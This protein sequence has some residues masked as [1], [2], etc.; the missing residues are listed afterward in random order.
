MEKG[1]TGPPGPAGAA[2]ERAD[3]AWTAGLFA[4]GLLLR[5][6]H[7]VTVRS[8]PF[9]EHLMLDAAMYDAW[10]RRIAAGALLGEGPFFQ[11]PLYAYFLGALYALAGHDHVTVVLVQSLL[12]SLVAPLIYLA[13][14]PWLSRAAAAA[15]GAI[16]ALYL[17]SIYYGGLILKTWMTV[18]LVALLLLLLSRVLRDEERPTG[19]LVV[20]LVLGLACLTRGNLVLLVPL[21]ALWLLARR[22]R[23]AA[24]AAALLVAGAALAIA[25]ATLHNRLAGGEWIPTT[26]NAGQNFYIGNNALNRSGE[27]AALPF[28]DPNPKHE[29]RDFAA[30]AR[31]RSGRD[32]GYAEA[33]RFWFGEALDWIGENPRAWLALLGRKLGAYWGAYEI[34]DNLDYY[35]YR[36]SAPVLR[37]PVPGFGLVAPLAVLGAVLAWRRPGWPRLLVLLVAVYSLSVVFFFVFSR[38]RMAAMPALFALAGFGLV[39]LWR[40]TGQALRRDGPM[41]LLR[42]AA[43]L[44]LFLALINLPLRAQQGSLT[45]RIAESAGIPVRVEHS[46]TALFNLGLSHA[47]RALEEEE[48]GESLLL[49]ER[50]LRQAVRL[51][52]RFA[53]VHVE[54]GKVLARQGRNA[55]AIEVYLDA[56]AIEPANYRVQHALG[57]LHRRLKQPVEAEARFR[58]ALQLAPNHAASA[59]RLGELLVELGRPEEAEM[60]FRRA[61]RLAPGSAAARRGLEAA[62]RQSGKAAASVP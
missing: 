7:L 34:P 23:S 16:A 30:E 59:I 28:V 31:R 20:G 37:L 14:K 11:D 10:G 36:E 44:L 48:P 52:P 38:F 18:V 55:E 12:G 27:Y 3:R 53:E 24:P 26:A 19:W 46:A 15:G 4:A 49:A 51:D 41:P 8:S 13:A 47:A 50:H 17:P 25:P 35:L 57:L 6:I 22:G 5:V 9:F 54:L 43:L 45:Q 39:E 42:A 33:S 2:W 56:E 40:R 60:L 32:L 1:Q 29:Q 62:L 21:L 61:L 58:R